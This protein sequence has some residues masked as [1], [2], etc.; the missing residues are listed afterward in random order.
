MALFPPC[1]LSLCLQIVFISMAHTSLP[2]CYL[3]PD[4]RFL[5]APFLPL[6]V[7]FLVLLFLLLYSFYRSLNTLIT[8][9][10]NIPLSSLLI[11]LPLLIL[12]L[13]Y[14]LSQIVQMAMS[15]PPALLVLSLLLPPLYRSLRF[16]SFLP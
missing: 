12:T 15:P 10:L 9:I 1:S 16:F 11:S 7:I 5:Y 13:R 3:L 8:H 4:S 6:L 14:L 2:L